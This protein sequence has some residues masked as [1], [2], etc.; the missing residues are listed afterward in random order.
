MYC[1]ACGT[2]CEGPQTFCG[3]CGHTL[4]AAAPAQQQTKTPS[5][6]V[7]QETGSA[8]VSDT[9][10][11]SEGANHTFIKGVVALL[12]IA[13]IIYV[14]AQNNQSGSEFAYQGIE[15]GDSLDSVKEKLGEGEEGD[16]SNPVG[17]IMY[18]FDDGDMQIMIRDGKVHGITL[19]K[20][21]QRLDN[22]IAIGV[23]TVKDVIEEYGEDKLRNFLDNQDTIIYMTE[24]AIIGF[25]V[26][27]SGDD[28]YEGD[29][30]TNMQAFD[31]NTLERLSGQDFE[32]TLS[33]EPLKYKREAAE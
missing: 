22:G 14:F 25:G 12:I 9:V 7:P 11:A 31:R 6:D 21:G 18:S 29:R 16:T 26:I 8:S 20:E 15:L 13:V 33:S 27:S 2:K 24:D 19:P 17:V 32:K 1:T 5:A 28:M 30:V 23:S 3:S 4:E 10:P